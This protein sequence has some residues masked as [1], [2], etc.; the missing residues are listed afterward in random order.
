MKQR[1]SHVLRFRPETYTR[2]RA[3]Y[4]APPDQEI[5]E[6]PRRL[7]P[8]ADRLRPDLDGHAH[9]PDTGPVGFWIKAT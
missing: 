1:K 7:D 4:P 2:A 6:I 3:L 9:D 5:R 8:E